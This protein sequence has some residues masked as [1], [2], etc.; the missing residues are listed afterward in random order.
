MAV[1]FLLTLSVK[2][3]MELVLKIMKYYILEIIHR[4]LK[5][6]KPRRLGGGF[7]GKKESGQLRFGGRDRP[8]K[9]PIALELKEQDERRQRER[10][11]RAKEDERRRR[12]KS[13]DRRRKSPVRDHKKKEND[14]RSKSPFNANSSEF[15]KATDTKPPLKESHS[16]VNGLTPKDGERNN[17][18]DSNKAATNEQKEKPKSPGRDSQRSRRRSPERGRKSKDNKRRSVSKDKSTKTTKAQS[19]VRKSSRERQENQKAVSPVSSRG[20]SSPHNKPSKTAQPPVTPL[21][22]N[23]RRSSPRSRSPA[24]PSS[25]KRSKHLRET[26]S[27]R[28]WSPLSKN[29]D[30]DNRP[31]ERDGHRSRSPLNTQ[32]SVVPRN[33]KDYLPLDRREEQR[34]RVRSREV[35][36][37]YPSPALNRDFERED[38]LYRHEDIAS[39]YREGSPIE[40]D[41]ALWSPSY[42]RS[43]NDSF[44]YR[45][46]SPYS[47]QAST[48]YMDTR[49]E[50]Y[51][52]DAYNNFDDYSTNRTDEYQSPLRE[53]S[54]ER[55]YSD[56]NDQNSYSEQTYS[57]YDRYRNS[58][59]DHQ[60]NQIRDDYD[61]NRRVYP[62]QRDEIGRRDAH[63]NNQTSR[64][65]I[66][67]V[68]SNY[69][70]RSERVSSENVRNRSNILHLKKVAS[71][72][73]R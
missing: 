60:T 63:W 25:S 7:G 40:N 14:K 46:Q 35:R 28:L 9:K 64:S 66:G 50:N 55:V 15:K 13:R 67:Q 42:G 6:W 27:F 58:Y 20:R 11:R 45:R 47:R 71:S 49:Y 4:L 54:I 70:F 52:R 10:D 73:R 37:R 48:D 12:E 32:E 68:E 26:D 18:S 51:T 17:F 53:R 21:E 5:G 34:S 30:F 1:Q 38:N 19:P 61:R 8:F 39:S 43:G 41:R 3:N 57:D 44:E 62:H 29:R 65:S 24:G 72:F 33:L 22:R 23:S 56:H 16:D 69:Q 36:Q 31:L 2:G 59:D